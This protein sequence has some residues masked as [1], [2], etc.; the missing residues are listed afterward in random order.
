MIAHIF[1]KSQYYNTPTRIY[2]DS[3]WPIRERTNISGLFS[4]QFLN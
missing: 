2:F 1:F 4:Q 3:H